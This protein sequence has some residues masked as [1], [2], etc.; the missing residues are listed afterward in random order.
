MAYINYNIDFGSV[1]KRRRTK[2]YLPPD[3][4]Y[5]ALIKFRAKLMELMAKHN[6]LMIQVKK[7]SAG[8]GEQM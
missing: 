5:F 6:M 2:T 7:G 3:G 4:I 8:A 1:R